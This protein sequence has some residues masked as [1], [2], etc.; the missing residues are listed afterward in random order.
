MSFSLTVGSDVLSLE[1]G[2]WRVES[3]IRLS[4]LVIAKS[5]KG[6]HWL[7]SHRCIILD[8]FAFGTSTEG[9]ERHY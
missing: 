9:F 5:G 4:H 7:R 3:S 6:L 8:D 1:V 2:K